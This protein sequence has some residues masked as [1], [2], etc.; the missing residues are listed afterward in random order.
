MRQSRSH[1]LRGGRGRLA[2]PW[3]KSHDPGAAG[4]KAVQRE[5]TGSLCGYLW[6]ARPSK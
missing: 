6:A 1:G 5:L 3:F 2:E 4:T